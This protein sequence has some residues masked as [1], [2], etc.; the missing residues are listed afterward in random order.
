LSPIFQTAGF[1]ASKTI[2]LEPWLQQTKK[3]NSIS[4]TVKL[5]TD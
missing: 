4:N 1:A 5:N 2:A 3:I